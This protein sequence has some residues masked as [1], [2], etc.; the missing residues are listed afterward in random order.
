MRFK[1]WTPTGIRQ[2]FTLIWPD[3][4]GHHPITTQAIRRRPNDAGHRRT[5]I[6]WHHRQHCTDRSQTNH[7]R[8]PDNQWDQK[9]LWQSTVAD[10]LP[11]MQVDARLEEQQSVTVYA[12]APGIC[13]GW[14]SSRRLGGLKA[15]SR[16]CLICTILPPL[17]AAAGK[18]L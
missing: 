2:S 1:H 15:R 14:C 3:R 12:V 10:R 18:G 9:G 6:A 5:L 8:V 4:P 13:L 17:P 7:R 16:I 11:S